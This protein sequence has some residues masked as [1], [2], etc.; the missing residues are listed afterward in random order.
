MVSEKDYRY[1]KA[2]YLSFLSKCF[3]QAFS[4]PIS[5]ATVPFLFLRIVLNLKY[6]VLEDIIIL[7]SKKCR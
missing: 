3:Q 7:I 2:R 1:M 4:T 6:Y 5:K